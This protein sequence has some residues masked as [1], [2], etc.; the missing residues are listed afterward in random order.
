M[1]LIR[2]EFNIFNLTLS[3]MPILLKVQGD[4]SDNYRTVIY[5]KRLRELVV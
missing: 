3:V 1:I 2:R 4:E 5:L